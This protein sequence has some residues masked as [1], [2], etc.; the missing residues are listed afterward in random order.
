[1]I[2]CLGGGTP[3]KP[4]I[5]EM[6]GQV[7]HEATACAQFLVEEKVCLDNYRPCN[8]DHPSSN[9]LRM[10]LLSAICQHSC[11]QGLPSNQIL[12]EIS[13]YDTVGNGYFAAT[14]HA[15]P[16]DWRYGLTSYCLFYFHNQARSLVLTGHRHV[17]TNQAFYCAGILLW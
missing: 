1:M 7:L 16:A 12:K 11:L 5:L 10:P 3:H 4:A 8:L 9:V 6:N 17:P 13:S 15:V 14:I 2:L